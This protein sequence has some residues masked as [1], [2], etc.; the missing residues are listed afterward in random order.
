MLPK[1]RD[2][3][4]FRFPDEIVG[5]RQYYGRRSRAGHRHRAVLVGMFEMIGGEG[6]EARRQRRAVQIGELIGVQLDG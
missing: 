5:A 3:R 4:R 6:A 1:Q 2:R